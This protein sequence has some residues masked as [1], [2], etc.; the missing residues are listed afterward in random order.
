V[1]NQEPEE[2]FSPL[3]QVFYDATA[4]E[5]RE[6]LATA[7]LAAQLLRRQKVFRQ[8]R[9]SEETEEGGKLILYVDRIGNR[10]IEVR[11]PNFTYAELEAARLRLMDRLMALESGATEAV[12]P[13]V[14][15]GEPEPALAAVADN[16][17]EAMET[18]E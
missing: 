4:S 2:N 16:A 5:Q 14:E 1:A 17:T 13:D 15:I 11:D 12:V 6:E 3:R 9:E 8:V 7:F 10:L 18:D